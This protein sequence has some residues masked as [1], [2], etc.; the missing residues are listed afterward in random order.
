M[1]IFDVGDLREIFIKKSHKNLIVTLKKSLCALNFRRNLDNIINK[2]F[3]TTMNKN[4][5]EEISR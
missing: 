5:D 3:P 2:L 1:I 4:K